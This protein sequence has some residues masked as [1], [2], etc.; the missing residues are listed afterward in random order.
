MQTHTFAAVFDSQSVDRTAGI[1]K[2]VAVATEG[3]ILDGRRDPVS[4]LPLEF[5]VY[6]GY[7]QVRYEVALAWGVA[8]IASRH[9]A[10]ILG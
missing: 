3:D 1:I 10:M 4:G 8:T 9:A 2:G 5:S 6:P 7:R